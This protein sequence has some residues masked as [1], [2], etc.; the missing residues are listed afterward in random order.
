VPPETAP[1]SGDWNKPA[2]QPRHNA[3]PNW[4]GSASASRKSKNENAN[5]KKGRKSLRQNGK[6]GKSNARKSHGK[7]A[8]AWG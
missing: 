1:T 4:S 8:A 6:H 3:G 5:G 2:Q 7:E